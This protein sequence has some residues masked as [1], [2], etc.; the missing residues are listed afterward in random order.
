V[1]EQ[2]AFS[3]NMGDFIVALYGADAP[4]TVD[5]FLYYVDSRYFPG[6]IFHRV[7]GN[8]MIQGG[9]YNMDGSMDVTGPPIDLEIIPGM[10][11]TSGVISM[12]R[13]DDPNSATSQF[14]ICVGDQEHL[15]GAYAAFG[16]VVSGYEVVDEISRV[17]T[18]VSD[19]PLLN[20]VIHTV[21]RLGG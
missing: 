13:T 12:A 17:Q 18:D 4:I 3:T 7:I 6:K 1:T 2:L 9:G 21:G 15:D 20:V 10:K 5:N 19:K 16:K 11:H 14:F 8:F